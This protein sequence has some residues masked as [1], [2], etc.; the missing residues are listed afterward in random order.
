MSN[1]K[2]RQLSLQMKQSVATFTPTPGTDVCV[3]TWQYECAL[4]VNEFSFKKCVFFKEIM[5]YLRF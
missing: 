1:R 4:V 2:P 3:Y 5:Q